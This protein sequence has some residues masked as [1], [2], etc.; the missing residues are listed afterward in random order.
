[1]EGPEATEKGLI[2][3]DRYPKSSAYLIFKDRN[4]YLTIA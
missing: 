1:M 4:Y 2:Q 3:K